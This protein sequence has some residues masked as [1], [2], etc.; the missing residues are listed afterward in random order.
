MGVETKIS[1]NCAQQI[2][3]YKFIIG[4]NPIDEVANTH[5]A[6]FA[7]R[8]GRDNLAT[9]RKLGNVKNV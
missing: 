4:L 1:L 5:A 8:L 2:G 3:C 6:P 7:I 9:I